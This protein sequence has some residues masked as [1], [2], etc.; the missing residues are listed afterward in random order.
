VRVSDM[1][2]KPLRN[3]IPTQYVTWF[4]LYC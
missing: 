1:K 2:T 3:I 4:C